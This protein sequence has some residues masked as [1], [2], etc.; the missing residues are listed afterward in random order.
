MRADK[1][2]NFLCD[3]HR[4]EKISGCRL[5][6]DMSGCQKRKAYNRIVRAGEPAVKYKSRHFKMEL[7]GDKFLE[8]KAKAKKGKE[9]NFQT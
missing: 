1:C 3:N 8:E 2:I 9:V 4:K 6:F 5:V 7:I